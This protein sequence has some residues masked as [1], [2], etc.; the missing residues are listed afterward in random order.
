VLYVTELLGLVAIYL[1]YDM[2]RKDRS[3]SLHANQQVDAA[4][5]L[6]GQV[7]TGSPGQAGR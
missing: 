1:G 3:A 7:A 2:M 6:P 5:S 4:E